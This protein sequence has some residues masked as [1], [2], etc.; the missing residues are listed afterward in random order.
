MTKE[1]NIN[2]EKIH[3]DLILQVA[4]LVGLDI[5]RMKVDMKSSEVDSEIQRSIQ[6]ARSLGLTG[7][8]AFIIGTEIVPGAT[9]LAT[10][11]SMVDDA[12]HN[13]D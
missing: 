11:K 7:T 4:E 13:L 9:D 2:E 12:R 5:D 10:L 8:P 1:G 3:E 6:V